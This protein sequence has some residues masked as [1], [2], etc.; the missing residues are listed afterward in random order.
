MAI[1]VNPPARALFPILRGLGILVSNPST[2][3]LLPS[4]YLVKIRR[5][6][7]VN[8]TAWAHASRTRVNQLFISARYNRGMVASSNI[9]EDSIVFSFI[10]NMLQTNLAIR[11]CRDPCLLR[12]C[13]THLGQVIASVRSFAEP[14]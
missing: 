13:A 6:S 12:C 5:Y 3:Q 8:V 10:A 14:S 4:K 9:C 2:F 7:N 1:E 11:L